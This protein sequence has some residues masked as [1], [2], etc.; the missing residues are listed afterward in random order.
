MV[1]RESLVIM[2][3]KVAKKA[4][5]VE[6]SYINEREMD[7]HYSIDFLYEQAMKCKFGLSIE[8]RNSLYT[9]LTSST[10]SWVYNFKG[11]ARFRQL[12]YEKITRAK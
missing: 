10:M 12:E 7:K 6:R 5:L 2:K 3:R 9:K 11:Q 1:N 4:T 8:A